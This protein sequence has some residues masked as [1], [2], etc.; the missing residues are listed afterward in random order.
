MRL[1]LEVSF[2]SRSGRVWTRWRDEQGRERAVRTAELT[3]RVSRSRFPGISLAFSTSTINLLGSV[4]PN[5]E[6]GRVME[7]GENFAAK[8]EP[9]AARRGRITEAMVGAMLAKEEMRG[10]WATVLAGPSRDGR[11]LYK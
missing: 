10:H 8:T 1:C 11:A 4:L 7:E 2:S 6:L 3:E 5:R 9:V